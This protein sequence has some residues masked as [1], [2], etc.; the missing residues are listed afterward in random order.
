M[1]KA[2]ER[3][4]LTESRTQQ[5]IISNATTFRFECFNNTDLTFTIQ[6]FFLSF[7]SCVSTIVQLC[8]WI[9]IVCYNMCRECRSSQVHFNVIVR[10]LCR[11][12]K[13]FW[14]ANHG[15]DLFII[16]QNCSSSFFIPSHC[17]S[18]RSLTSEAIKFNFLQSEMQR[19]FYNG[20]GLIWKLWRLIKVAINI[21]LQKETCLE[22]LEANS[23]KTHIELRLE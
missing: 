6:L 16:R 13:L 10:R 12:H 9:K 17:T 1:N 2:K 11:I 4:L 7:I 22:C 20:A 3:I 19:T 8:L 21:W 18:S 23:C 15:S 5:E 14:C